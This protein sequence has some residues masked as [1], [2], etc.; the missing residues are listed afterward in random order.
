MNDS[1]L[2]VPV[3][4]EAPDREKLTIL[5]LTVQSRLH[6]K[7]HFF[8]IQVVKGKWIAWYEIDLR[9]R[10]EDGQNGE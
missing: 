10:L 4:I 5:M 6:A 2:T 7:V 9:K 3:S 1:L 8:D